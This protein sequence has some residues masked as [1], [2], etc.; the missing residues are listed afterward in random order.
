[1]DLVGW[2]RIVGHITY[3]LTGEPAIDDP[4]CM[5]MKLWTFGLLVAAAALLSA[6]APFL[7][8]FDF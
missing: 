4:L 2:H 1:M 8:P 3:T 5:R 7:G 6:C